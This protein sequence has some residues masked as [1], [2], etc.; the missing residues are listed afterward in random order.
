MAHESSHENYHDRTTLSKA[1]CNPSTWMPEEDLQ[2]ENAHRLTVD[3]LKALHERRMEI[4]PSGQHAGVSEHIIIGIDD[5]I[6]VPRKLISLSRTILSHLIA[7]RS[8]MTEEEQ[9]LP[10]LV[11]YLFGCAYTNSPVWQINLGHKVNSLYSEHTADEICAYLQDF[12]DIPNLCTDVWRSRHAAARCRGAVFAGRLGSGHPRQDTFDPELTR[13]ILH[14][15]CEVL[16]RASSS[17]RERSLKFTGPAQ[18]VE[19][20]VPEPDEPQNASGSVSLPNFS[21]DEGEKD[22]DVN[23]D[24][25][26]SIKRHC[27]TEQGTRG[28]EKLRLAAHIE[29]S[30]KQ[31]TSQDVEG[32]LSAIEY[33]SKVFGINIDRDSFRDIL[34]QCGGTTFVGYRLRLFPIAGSSLS[35]MNVDPALFDRN[36]GSH[37]TSSIG[38]VLPRIEANMTIGQAD[39]YQLEHGTSAGRKFNVDEIYQQLARYIDAKISADPQKK[40]Y[41]HNP[42][43]VFM[44]TISLTV[45]ATSMR[46]CPLD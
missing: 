30:L 27:P 26:P 18:W 1:P 8:V 34:S 41:D 6:S 2:F 14:Y 13:T 42:V 28:A 29:D 11:M 36:H 4:D 16:D 35:R 39:A 44:E 10:T 33:S 22:D 40:E 23:E 46:I 38:V 20:E 45:I 32:T 19:K 37:A 31:V 24:D 12:D 21:P 5:M 17:Y 25:T 43:S 15:I 9:L 3:L 7:L